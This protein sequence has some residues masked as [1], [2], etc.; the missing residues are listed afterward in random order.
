MGSSKVVE[1]VKEDNAFMQ[2]VTEGLND[3]DNGRVVEFDTVKARVGR[4]DKWV[5]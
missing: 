1:A 3:L 2:A 5:K 4:N